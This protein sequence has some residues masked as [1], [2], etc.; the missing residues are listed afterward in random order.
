METFCY[1]CLYHY[2]KVFDQYV[3]IETQ[4]KCILDLKQSFYW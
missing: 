1:C 2:R 4:F 3:Y